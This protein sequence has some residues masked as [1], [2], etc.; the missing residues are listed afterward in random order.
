MTA[1]VFAPA[2]SAPDNATC[3]A[4]SDCESARRE[5]PIP[6]T[7]TVM[8]PPYELQR[9]GGQDLSHRYLPT[10]SVLAMA[11]LVQ[12]VPLR[13]Q[14]RVLQALFA[15]PR[16]VRRL[17]AGAPIRIDGQTLDLDAQLLLRMQQLSGTELHGTDVKQ[18]RAAI[19]AGRE[20][21]GGAP[22]EPVTTKDLQLPNDI[23]ARLYRRATCRR[24]RRCWSS[25]TAAVSRSAT[26]TAT[27]TCADSWRA[28]PACGCCPSATDWH[29]R[30][31]SRRRS[32]TV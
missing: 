10:G 16:P 5:P 12:S 31:R 18:A 8:R 30:T 6:T 23:P 26:S 19:R 28:T 7:V 17:I 9:A 27:T 25:S 14:A 20:L 22:I 3:S 1:I 15:L 32:T 21:V 4:R 29:L 13:W 11:S 2:S 24:A